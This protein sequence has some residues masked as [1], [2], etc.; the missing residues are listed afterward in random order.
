MTADVRVKPTEQALI[1]QITDDF[2]EMRTNPSCKLAD[3]GA[4]VA[5]HGNRISKVFT[6][7]TGR[8]LGHYQMTTLWGVSED[9]ADNLILGVYGRWGFGSHN[10]E[11]P[12]GQVIAKHIPLY[13]FK[14]QQHGRLDT[15][16]WATM[17]FNL[18]EWPQFSGQALAYF[19]ANYISEGRTQSAMESDKN[20]IDTLLR[21]VYPNLSFNLLMSLVELGLLDSGPDTINSW[22]DVQNKTPTTMGCEINTVTF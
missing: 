8:K 15:C 3:V 7:R 14:V 10:G 17:E 11:P 4:W 5:Q 19:L 18:N 1:A 22:L 16:L 13:A 2:A 6:G 20:N 9:A 12:D 21:V